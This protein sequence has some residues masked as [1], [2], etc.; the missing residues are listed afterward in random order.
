[1]DDETFGK[2]Q[3]IMGNQKRIERIK[4]IRHPFTGEPLKGASKIRRFKRFIDMHYP[5]LGPEDH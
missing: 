2:Y 5:V 3:R 1:M 4:Q